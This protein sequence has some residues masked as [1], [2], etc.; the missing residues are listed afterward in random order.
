[1]LKVSYAAALAEDHRACWLL[2]A[3]DL[4]VCVLHVDHLACLGAGVLEPVELALE[5][6]EVAAFR[7]SGAVLI[8]RIEVDYVIKCLELLYCHIGR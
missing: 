6:N 1:M 3:H 4:D 7:D 5:E 2:H 8:E